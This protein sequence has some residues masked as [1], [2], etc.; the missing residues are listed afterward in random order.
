VRLESLDCFLNMIVGDAADGE[1]FF[2]V[3]VTEVDPW[4]R[5]GVVEEYFVEQFA[6]VGVVP[7]LYL[8]A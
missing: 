7:D 4:V 2:R 6:F 1:S 5:W 8:V 3:R